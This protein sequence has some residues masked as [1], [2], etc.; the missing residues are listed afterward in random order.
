MRAA[1]A[2]LVLI[3]ALPL[4]A[5]DGTSRVSFFVTQP[6]FGWSEGGGSDWDGGVGLAFEKRFT[7]RWSAEASISRDHF[8]ETVYSI[9]PGGVVV[10]TREATWYPVDV[11]VRYHFNIT[12]TRWRPYAGA[13]VWWVQAPDSASPEADDQLSPEVVGG[14]DFNLTERW[15]L[16]VDAKQTFGGDATFR[17]SVGVGL[18]F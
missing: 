13:G 17:P 1:A 7:P 2:V 11:S 8:S 18:R 6:G 15:S 12:H 5:Q 9:T 3:A 4:F 14:V 16:R 10:T